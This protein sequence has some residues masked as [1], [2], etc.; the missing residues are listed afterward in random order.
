[1]VD[2][3]H[4]W[5]ALNRTIVPRNVFQAKFLDDVVKV[6]AAKVFW[7]GC[8]S[9]ADLPIPSSVVVCRRIEW[10]SSRPHYKPDATGG[11]QQDEN[12]QLQPGES[13]PPALGLWCVGLRMNRD[14]RSFV[15][16]SL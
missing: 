2:A 16:H 6:L 1:M 8:N 3:L 9:V 15:S 4:A 14:H 11:Q 7:I 10:K 13:E 5:K 12:K